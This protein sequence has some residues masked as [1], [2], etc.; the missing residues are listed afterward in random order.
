M[1]DEVLED[2]PERGFLQI[3]QIGGSAVFVIPLISIVE[4][5]AVCKS[6]AQRRAV[7]VDQELVALG[8]S[9]V[10]GAFVH[11]M[12]V[13]GSISTTCVNAVSGVRT[14]FGGIWA[15]TI[16]LLSLAFLTPYVGYI[17]LPALGAIV[18]CAVLH[19]IEYKEA[20]D[21]WKTKRVDMVPMM[22]TFLACLVIGLEW[23]FLVGVM[24]N[25][26]MLLIVTSHPNV[27][28]LKFQIS[29]DTK[30]VVFRPDRFLFYPGI[31]KVRNLINKGAKRNKDSLIVVDCIN[32]VDIDFTAAKGLGAVAIS[33]KLNQRDLVFVNVSHPVDKALKGFTSDGVV[34]Y[35]TAQD[36]IN[37]IEQKAMSESDK[38]EFGVLLRSLSRLDSRNDETE[39]HRIDADSEDSE[40]EEQSY[41]T[42]V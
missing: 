42:R 11:S 9:Q 2:A 41:S 25:L 16:V 19:F 7:D 5:I 18:I 31:Q 26:L 33:L 21:V 24:S 13:T 39:K 27:P 22:V 1:V 29:D 36:W 23:G 40:N 12:P 34:T 20:M 30:V 10:L 6:F 37:T 17:P 38:E 32:L 4:H 8:V 3:L 15:G 14:T 28:T 35:E